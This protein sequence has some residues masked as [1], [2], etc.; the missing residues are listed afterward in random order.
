M[1]IKPVL[2]LFGI[3]T[4]ILLLLLSPLVIVETFVDPYPNSIWALRILNTKYIVHAR[5]EL[6]IDGEPLVLE[7]SIRCFNAVDYDYYPSSSPRGD[8]LS[9]NGSTADTLAGKTKS[10]RLFALHVADA[11]SVLRSKM[12][13]NG[14]LFFMH[15]NLGDY[16]Y[17]EP[18]YLSKGDIDVPVV[19]ELFGDRKSLKRVDVYL[20]KKRI[21]EGYHGVKLKE[22]VVSRVPEVIEKRQHKGFQGVPLNEFE[23]SRKDKPMMYQ[24]WGEYD[25]FGRP[26]WYRRASNSS[27]RMLSSYYGFKVSSDHFDLI[28][29]DFK[30]QVRDQEQ[31]NR[32]IEEY[33]G[34][35]DKTLSE[36]NPF[37]TYHSYIRGILGYAFLRGE[38]TVPNHERQ[39]RVNR[40]YWLVEE[41]FPCLI[42]SKYMQKVTFAC[43]PE[44][45]G[46]LSFL[47]YSENNFINLRNEDVIFSFNGQN[48][49]NAPKTFLFHYRA[50]EKAVYGF[51]YL[52]ASLAEGR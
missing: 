47:S 20:S 48:F 24:D 40:V 14:E 2:K 42:E 23:L 1:S 9:S 17:L 43:D 21:R 36:Y 38:L 51:G 44:K 28:S 52:G 5:A 25:W 37:Y 11:C 8:V 12:R 13:N 33:S 6:E 50:A 15:Q 26:N 3:L 29:D 31:A 22:L 34:Q 32:L 10:G 30:K 18:V 16:Q 39:V 27:T 19:Y 35:A 49:Y 7:R 4:T 46:V 45:T 41:Y